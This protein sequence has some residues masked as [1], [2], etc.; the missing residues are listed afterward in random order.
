MFG[1][2]SLVL[3]IGCEAVGSN[4]FAAMKSLGTG[5]GA[6]I[7]RIR[8]NYKGHPVVISAQRTRDRVIKDIQL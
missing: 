7:S 5:C 1:E 3:A 8:V 2:L 4:Y 6:V